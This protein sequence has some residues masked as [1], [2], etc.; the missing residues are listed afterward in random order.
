MHPIEV[1]QNIKKYL[2]FIFLFFQQFSK[3]R[4]LTSR[5]AA[6]RD[7]FI[8]EYDKWI[9]LLVLVDNAGRKL[10]HYVAF[11]REKLPTDETE[12]Y[13]ELE[14][15]I[16]NSKN[17]H[18]KEDQRNKLCP[19]TK[20]TDPNEFDLTLWTAIIQDKFGDKYQSF[21]NDL[22]NARNNLFHLGNKKLSDQKFKQL[23]DSNMKMLDYYGFNTKLVGDLET[24]DIFCHQWM[25]NMDISSYQGNI[26]LTFGII[27]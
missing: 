5:M 27:S 20:K 4:E 3:C 1:K 7:K 16:K 14:P 21:R 22:R 17:K 10:C 6:E 18:Y 15:L 25:K 19:S 26:N 2:T 12:L 13:L 24:C 8:Q 9:R 11:Q 23:W